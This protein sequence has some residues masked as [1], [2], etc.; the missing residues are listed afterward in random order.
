MHEAGGGNVGI[1][2]DLLH[3]GHG[4]GEAGTLVPRYGFAFA[5][6]L[7]S[8]RQ[9]I[10]YRG[11]RYILPTGLQRPAP[12]QNVKNVTLKVLFHVIERGYSI[13]EIKG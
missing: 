9:R 11:G 4:V 2:L 12:F 6:Y 5:A 7:F 10:H 3:D 1:A 8:H 13:G